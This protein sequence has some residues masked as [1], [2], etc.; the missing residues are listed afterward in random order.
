MLPPDRSRVV[1]SALQGH[2]LASERQRQPFALDESDDDFLA[3]DDDEDFALPSGAALKRN[4]E[5][6]EQGASKKQKASAE[7]AEKKDSARPSAAAPS[8][9]T[10]AA[11]SSSQ[12]ENVSN[13]T[14]PA[15]PT[16]I[17]EAV[18]QYI[19]DLNQPVSAQMV[20]D[21]FRG[22]VSKA[23]VRATCLPAAGLGRMHT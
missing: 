19:V 1:P 10:S 5:K 8:F 15:L 6:A 20:A 11:A 16:S 13:M 4:K 3:H 21:H 12:K 23:Q 14:A 18:L 2:Q 7:A 17:E 9:L 22:S